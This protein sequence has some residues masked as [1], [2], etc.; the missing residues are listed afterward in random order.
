MAQGVLMVAIAGGLVA[1]AAATGWWRYA[2]S[3][4]RIPARRMTVRHLGLQVLDPSSV[5]RVDA[6][7]TGFAGGFNQMIARPSPKAWEIYCASLPALI[8]PF[9]HEGAAMGYTPRHLFRYDPREFEAR[10]VRPR[11][12]FRYL[13][14]VGLGFWSGMRNHDARR[15]ERVADGLDPLHRFLCFD[16]YGFKHA[17]FDYPRDASLLRRLDLL[18]GYAR[19]AA[20]QGV[21]R[22][23]YFLFMDRPDVLIERIRALGRHAADVASGLGLAAVFINP[24]RLDRARELARM[25]PAEW[26]AQFHLGMCFGLKA[27]AI[28]DLDQFDRDIATQSPAVQA[29][30]RASIR[31]C[32]RIELLVRADGESDPYRRWRERVADWMCANIEY[33]IAD[34]AIR[35]GSV[36]DRTIRAA[37]GSER[38]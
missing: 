30:I 37:S 20:Y 15:I 24:D 13:Y 26:Q 9:A 6:I 17:F 11:P 10:I 31:E 19:N 21:G 7:L 3:P 32:D 4:W 36:S 35:A 2:L 18:S 5:E 22:A 16:G 28:N 25:L 38:T 29:A 1:L 12:E 34:L 23:F 14:Y 33:P 8:R 27:R